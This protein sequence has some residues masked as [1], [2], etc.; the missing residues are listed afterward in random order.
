MKYC[1]FCGKE[2]ENDSVFCTECGKT[3]DQKVINKITPE[4]P[5][6][7][8]AGDRLALIALILYFGSAILARFSYYFYEFLAAVGIPETIVTGIYNATYIIPLSGLIVAIVGRVKYPK[9]SFCKVAFWII[10][11]LSFLFVISAVLL[12][13]AC[14]GTLSQCS[15]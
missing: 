7:K 11:L 1:P 4:S 14:V 8:K 6:E 10:L 5:E 2:L 3:A 13:M 9:N 12:V 15:G